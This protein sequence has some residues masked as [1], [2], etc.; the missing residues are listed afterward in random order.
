MRDWLIEAGMAV[1]KLVVDIAVFMF[2]LAFDGV[3]NYL[4]TFSGT[5]LEPY[6]SW[7][8]ILN[9]WL[10]FDACLALLLVYWG[11]VGAFISFKYVVKAFPNVG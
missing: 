10:P 2:S 3:L 5:W 8:T 6:V 9:Q 1:W 4:P 11:A 7:L